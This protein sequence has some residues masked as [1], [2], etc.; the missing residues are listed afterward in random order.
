M[1]FHHK[2]NHIVDSL[3]T[4]RQAMQ[5]LPTPIEITWYTNRANTQSVLHSH[6]YY[7][8]VL[9]IRGSVMYSVNGSLISLSEGELIILPA[10]IFHYGKYDISESVSERL[11][12]QIDRFLW[13]KTAEELCFSELCNLYVPLVIS[14]SSVSSWGFRS[15]FEH[16][17]L[18]RSVKEEKNRQVLS[19]VMMKTLQIYIMESL[20]EEHSRK[21]PKNSI[22][23]QAVQYIQ[24]EFTDPSL[25]V[26]NIAR[27]T[28]TSREHLSR[29]FKRY[30]M[31][32]IHNYVTELRMQF[33]H[34]QLSE[35]CSIMEACEGSG[36]SDYSSFTRSFR[37]IHGMT[38]TQYLKNLR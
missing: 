31:Q 14:A 5:Q 22:V 8:L 27:H 15:L 11:L 24:H 29:V 28:Y 35:G 3:L 12:A 16:I 21:L 38:P 4:Q 25:T 1:P 10:E 7:E 26:L 23:E 2:L 37:R 36:F 18:L 30:T 9:P 33:F 17:D 6:P 32:S 20:G 34:Q 19:Q 13:D